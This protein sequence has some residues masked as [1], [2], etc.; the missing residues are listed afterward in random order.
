[1][2]RAMRQA[3]EA[4][5]AAR[6]AGRIPRKLHAQASTARRGLARPRVSPPARPGPRWSVIPLGH[7]AGQ[8]GEHRGELG[9]PDDARKGQ[10]V[11]ARLKSG[12][13]HERLLLGDHLARRP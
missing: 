4:G 6:R 1:M 5:Y 2:A 3:V 12:G 8:I 7:A 9:P 10:A 11:K 13:A